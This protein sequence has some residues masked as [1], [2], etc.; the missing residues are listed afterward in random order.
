MLAKEAGRMCM[1]IFVKKGQINESSPFYWRFGIMAAR[2]W[3]FNR[4][5][6]KIND[7][8]FRI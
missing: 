1:G 4:K 2:F 5:I 7:V 8:N 3:K 6:S